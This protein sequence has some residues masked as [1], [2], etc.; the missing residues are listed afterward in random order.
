MNISFPFLL[1]KG[2]GKVHAL[3]MENERGQN[4]MNTNKTLRPVLDTSKSET[5]N[6]CTGLFS[7]TQLSD[8]FDLVKNREHWKGEIS[9]IIFPVEVEL[10]QAAI[11]FY[12]ATEM[13][14]VGSRHEDGSP[15]MLI[16]S[17]AGYWNGPAN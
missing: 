8:A 4:K 9:A 11:S 5:P 7:E 17:A 12:T 2:N 13:K 6:C 14:I 3:I 1:D 16:V 10:V 15:K